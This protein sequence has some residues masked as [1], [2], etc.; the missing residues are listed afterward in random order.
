M[1]L[2]QRLL[3]R[4]RREDGF[5][6]IELVITV[7][8]LGIIAVALC[9]VVLQYVKTTV[10]TSARLNESTDEQF[11]STYWQNDVSSL[12]RRSFSTDPVTRLGTVGVAQSVYVGSAGPGGCGSSVGSVAVAF[13]WNQFQMGAAVPDDAWHTTPQEVAYVTVP[14]GSRLL[15]ER[16]RCKDG[17]Q[18][19]PVAVAHNLTGTPT[20]SCDTTCT[21]ATPPNRVSMTFV[22]KDAGNP[23][24]P[25]YTTTV[26]A[27]RRQG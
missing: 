13:A 3:Q 18:S 11:I 12:G 26:S 24:S 8:I 2:I 21:A 15:L 14:N 10:D 27:D 19:S 1:Q 22:V 16:V 5:T 9:G 7:A 23:S 20:I 6:L 17:A 25:G 4:A